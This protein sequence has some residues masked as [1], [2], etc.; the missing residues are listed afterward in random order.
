MDAWLARLRH[1]LVKYAVWR[2]RDLDEAGAAP[3]PGDL[4]ALRRSLFELRDHEGQSA[5]ATGLFC[6][7][8]EEIDAPPGLLDAFAKTLKEAESAVRA[9]D[10]RPESWRDAVDAT[11]RIESA[12]ETLAR[13]LK[14]T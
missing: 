5:S 8:R 2:A 6:R 4:G 12:F 9:L 11:L 3:S 1:D 14:R 13:A 7:M 10:R